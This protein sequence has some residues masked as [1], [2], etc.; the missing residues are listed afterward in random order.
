MWTPPQPP[1]GRRG[2]YGAGTPGLPG[3]PGPPVERVRSPRRGQPEQRKRG[4]N[5]VTDGPGFALVLAAALGSGLMA[6]VFY[7]FSTGVMPGL[8]RLPEP[9]GAAAMQA[10]NIAVINPL[11]LGA[12]V[13]TALF[14]VATG[15]TAV[16]SWGDEGSLAALVGSACY[17]VGAVVVT[18]AANVPLNNALAAA[19]PASPEGGALWRRYLVRWTA[20]NHVRALASL[21]ACAAFILALAAR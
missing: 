12:F 20:W 4:V 2:P 6:G 11:F 9:P 19:D 5:D 14:C 3:L 8:R 18:A 21:A 10:I 1:T 13:G 15:V 7:A 16:V 17:L